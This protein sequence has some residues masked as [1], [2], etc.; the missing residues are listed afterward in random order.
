M[1]VETEADCPNIAQ[2]QGALLPHVLAGI[3]RTPTEHAVA[4]ADECRVPKC[5]WHVP[6]SLTYPDDQERLKSG[7]LIAQIALAKPAVRSG[8][9]RDA[10]DE[11]QAV[12]AA[13]SAA[14]LGWLAAVLLVSSLLCYN[15]W[16]D[17]YPWL[18]TCDDFKTVPACSYHI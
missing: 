8:D 2:L 18:A 3:P 1:F 13:P 6:N 4:F 17:C 12:P 7:R 5:C 15:G 14:K 11:Y 16:D 9:C 10:N